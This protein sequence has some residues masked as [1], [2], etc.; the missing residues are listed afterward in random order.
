MSRIAGRF[1]FFTDWAPGKSGLGYNGRKRVRAIT[2]H[3]VDVHV[4][5][6][7]FT[8]INP[9]LSSER[10]RCSV[11]QGLIVICALWIFLVILVFSLYRCWMIFVPYRGST[12]SLLWFTSL[13]IFVKILLKLWIQL[14]LLF[15]LPRKPPCF[16]LPLVTHHHFLTSTPSQIPN[17]S[18]VAIIEIVGLHVLL[19]V[20]VSSSL[21]TDSSNY[22]VSKHFLDIF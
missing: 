13:P 16:G 18:V 12:S 9:L 14:L 6:K 21:K 1:F 20:P 8:R 5:R 17:F 7:L 22:F 19:H 11:P 3:T 15:S 2:S 4:A 10:H